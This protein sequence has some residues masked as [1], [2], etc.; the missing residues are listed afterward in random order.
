M[1]LCINTVEDNGW[2]YFCCLDMGKIFARYP[3]L[4]LCIDNDRLMKMGR[5]NILTNC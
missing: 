5:A 2:N 3:S 4:I 1:V